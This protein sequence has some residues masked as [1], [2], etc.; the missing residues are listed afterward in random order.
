MKNFIELTAAIVSSGCNIIPILALLGL[1]GF[2]LKGYWANQKKRWLS[3][4]ELAKHNNFTFNSGNF[5]SNAE[6]FGNY[7]GYY[8]NLQTCKRNSDLGYKNCTVIT[9]TKRNLETNNLAPTNQNIFDTTLTVE[10]ITELFTS[11]E[12]GDG[13]WE[14]VNVELAGQRISYEK[15]GIETNPEHLQ[16]LF[17]WLENVANI[18]PVIVAL[19][20]TVVPFL[21]ATVKRDSRLEPL[22]TQLLSEIAQETTSRLA[23]NA[24]Q[25]FCTYCLTRCVAH[26]IELNWQHHITYYGCRICGQSR[27]FLKEEIVMILDSQTVEESLKQDGILK[28][29][30]FVHKKLFDFEEVE[31]IQATDEDVERFAVQIGNDTDPVRQPRYRQIQCI[32]SPDCHL[33][34]NTIRILQHLL[35]EVEIKETPPLKHLATL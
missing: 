27:E 33:S 30:W 25:L 5:F 21:H 18:Y 19:G 7:R 29:N 32:I 11:S 20:G 22:C 26:K 31:I 3:W 14:R 15:P 24:S 34:E 2:F 1:V 13:L 4:Q 8:L 35:G 9:L 23:E 12:L 6:V 10:Y 17:D 28:I 16:F